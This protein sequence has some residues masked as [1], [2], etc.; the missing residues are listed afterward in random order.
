MVDERPWR[1]SQRSHLGIARDTHDL[2]HFLPPAHLCSDGA[3]SRPVSTRH[4]LA[5][6]DDVGGVPGVTGPELAAGENRDPEQWEVFPGRPN[7][8]G[9]VQL[10]GDGMVLT[11]THAV[12]PKGKRS[13]SWGP[14]FA[15]FKTIRKEKIDASFAVSLKHVWGMK[16]KEAG[17]LKGMELV[18]M[19]GTKPLKADADVNRA[20]KEGTEPAKKKEDTPAMEYSRTLFELPQ[21][22]SAEMVYGVILTPKWKETRKT[23]EGFDALLVSIDKTAFAEK[24]K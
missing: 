5:D 2:E 9:D 13:I 7:L 11:W 12:A 22:G 10:D 6:D 4:F 18:A 3:V 19:A 24:K 1:L 14:A 17:K 23:L 21:E 16:G 15:E 20:K 8:I